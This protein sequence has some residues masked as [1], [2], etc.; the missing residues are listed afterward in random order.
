MRKDCT[1]STLLDWSGFCV[2]GRN[3]GGTKD[4]IRGMRSGDAFEAIGAFNSV[5]TDQKL[6][7]PE[8]RFARGH[9]AV[10]TVTDRGCSDLP[11]WRTPFL[12]LMRP[13]LHVV[14]ELPELLRN[15]SSMREF[16]YFDPTKEANLSSGLGSG[17]VPEDGSC[18]SCSH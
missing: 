3:D 16:D 17:Y 11:G 2:C 10:P 8:M 6:R 4:A 7:G 13:S 18:V 12:M 15:F 1:K 5:F 14:I 9:T